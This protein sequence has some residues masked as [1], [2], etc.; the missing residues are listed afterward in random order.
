MCS[1]YILD[2]HKA[3]PVDNKTWSKWYATADRKVARKQVGDV[4]VSTVFLAIN[5]AFIPHEPPILFETMIF[6]GDHDQYQERCA[7]WEAAEKMH[8]EACKLAFGEK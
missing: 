2:G 5:H 3:I 1:Y 7:T 8:E 6:G 4:L